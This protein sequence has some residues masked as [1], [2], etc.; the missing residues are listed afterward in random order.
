MQCFFFQAEDGIRDYDVT[1]VQ[2]CA[3]PIS[4]Q[5]VQ[6]FLHAFLGALRCQ[7]IADVLVNVFE[8]CYLLIGPFDDF[9]NRQA[10]IRRDRIGVDPRGQVRD[11]LGEAL[12]KVVHADESPGVGHRRR[13]DILAAHGL[14]IGA[15]LELPRCCRSEARRVG[16]ERR[17]RWWPNP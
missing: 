2:T 3:L 9:Q 8:R 6:V 13:I 16:N 15:S 7:A 12:G 17:Y 4:S 11:R 5:V 1:G 10:E 14:E